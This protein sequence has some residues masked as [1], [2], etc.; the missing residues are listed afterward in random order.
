MAIS[1]EEI[2]QIAKAV[3]EKLVTPKEICNC[4]YKA[5]TIAHSIRRL[6]TAIEYRDLKGIDAELSIVH[7]DI[8][9]TAQACRLNLNP[10]RD[11]LGIV[12]KRSQEGFWPQAKDSMGEAIMF[13]DEHL[14]AFYK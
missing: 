5:W 6:I 11:L 7:K 2:E 3:A 14:Q 8:D 12:S 1:R 10:A 13:I 9:E 4:G